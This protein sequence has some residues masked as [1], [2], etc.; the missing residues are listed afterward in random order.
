MWMRLSTNCGG[1]QRFQ[2]IGDSFERKADS[3]SCWKRCWLRVEE[4]AVRVGSGAPKAG[5]YVPSTRAVT[6]AGT[7]APAFLSLPQH[8]LGPFVTHL[9][10]SGYVLVPLRES[11]DFT[12]YRGRKH[13]DPSPATFGT[14]L[15]HPSYR[16]SGVN[17]QVRQF[18]LA[19]WHAVHCLTEIPFV[20]RQPIAG[21]L[22]CRGACSKLISPF[23]ENLVHHR[24][25]DRSFPNRR[26]NTL[27]IARSYIP[28]GKHSRTTAFE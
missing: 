26:R 17:P 13:D 24:N 15:P 3:P 1:I 11:A 10:P 7:S 2:G 16:T 21:K 28:H 19:H 4:G 8:D 12:L 22:L 27:H 20:T 6:T 9:G 18:E 25:C 14:V 5:S 23:L